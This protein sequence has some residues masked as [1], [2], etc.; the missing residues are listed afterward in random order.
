MATRAREYDRFDEFTVDRTIG[1]STRQYRLFEAELKDKNARQLD[2]FQGLEK[3]LPFFEARTFRDHVHFQY[4]SKI[5]V[6]RWYPYREGYSVKLVDAFLNELG[7]SGNTF[8]P[9]AGSG[10][11]LLASRMR[12]LK[13]FG[14]DINP[15]STLIA[16]AENEKYTTADI[17][18][19]DRQTDRMTSVKESPYDF[20]ISFD[21]AMR[22]FNK[23]ILKSLLQ[24]K[25]HINRMEDDKVR[26]LFLLAWLSIIEDVSNI[27]KEGNGIKYKNR[28]RTPAGYVNIDK[29]AWE[30]LNFPPDKFNFVRDKLLYQLKV[31]SHDLRHNY[32]RCDKKPAIYDGSCLEFDRYFPDEI[33]FTFFSPPY[34]NCFD[35]FEIHKVELWLGEFVNNKDDINKLRSKG[36]RSNTGALANKSIT[37]HNDHLERLIE[38]FESTRL[39]NKKIPSV[40]RG[41]FDDMATLLGKIHCRTSKRGLVGI[42]VGNSA[43]SGV[44]IPTDELIADIAQ[45]IG[46]KVNGI[47]TARYLTTSSQQKRELESLRS[48][49][50]E[51]IVLLER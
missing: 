35:Y 46:F 29:D 33:Q 34:C 22:V 48:Y 49:L 25:Y 2:V 51:S 47:Y 6:Q 12:N 8:D 21:L 13:S 37:Y 27:K 19:F 5:P 9:F 42:V 30:R 38:M 23:E 44:I 16:R 18:E 45:E 1:E 26:R 32:G 24:F 7:I 14:V 50:R 31:I 4:T 40:V 20:H 3:R 15:V 41:Y 10:T 28:K 11:T 43:Y 36:F 17:E 39:W